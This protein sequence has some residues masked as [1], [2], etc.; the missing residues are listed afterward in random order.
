ML[1]DRGEP[2][3][4]Q[5]EGK[6]RSDVDERGEEQAKANSSRGTPWEVYDCSRWRTS[7]GPPCA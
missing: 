6:F 1:S 3:R 4:V 5:N 7:K 2:R